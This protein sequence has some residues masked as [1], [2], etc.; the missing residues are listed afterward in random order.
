MAYGIEM[1]LCCVVLCH[2]AVFCNCVIIVSC[3]N[4]VVSCDVVSCG[5]VSS[6]VLTLNYCYGRVF[7]VFRLFSLV[8]S[9]S[10]GSEASRGNI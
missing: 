2:N 6:G 5:V 1:V 9:S 7:S 8:P 4:G 10:P 3:C